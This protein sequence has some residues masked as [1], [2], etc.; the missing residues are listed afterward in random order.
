MSNLSQD[1]NWVSYLP[2]PGE[3]PTILPELGIHPTSRDSYD[4][5][6]SPS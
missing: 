4:L 2:Y 5:G 1:Y 6:R 3:S